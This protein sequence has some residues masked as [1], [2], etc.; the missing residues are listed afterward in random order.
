M[1]AALWQGYAVM[2]M[3]QG[4]FEIA[5]TLFKESITRSPNHAQS[6]QAWA[7][8]EAKQVCELLIHIT[9][10]FRLFGFSFTDS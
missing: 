10:M 7:C 1:H 8:L 4:K 5:R 9:Q 3:Q 6:Y 2:E